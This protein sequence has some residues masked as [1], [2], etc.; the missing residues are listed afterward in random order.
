V[1]RAHK[2][3]RNVVFAVALCGVPA[4]GVMPVSGVFVR[5]KFA[6]E[7]T[8]DT[9][10]VTDEKTLPLALKDVVLTM[11]TC[12][13]EALLERL[14]KEDRAA[15]EAQVKK[16]EFKPD[17]RALAGELKKG[18]EISGAD[19][20]FGELRLAAQLYRRGV[21]VSVIENALVLAVT[22]RLMRPA[23]APPLGTICSLA[24]FL[25]VIEEVLSLSLSPDHYQYLR[26]KL[27]RVAQTQ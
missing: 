3:R 7:V 26:R 6:P 8:P 20:R 13:W 18:E 23:D 4:L 17:K 25:P 5:L 21:S 9:V 11:P 24:Y 22:R 12:L 15:F 2:S 14:G 1:A 10:T 19:L 16:C 27:E